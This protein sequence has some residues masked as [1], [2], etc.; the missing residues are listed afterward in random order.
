MQGVRAGTPGEQASSGEAR[1]ATSEDARSGTDHLMKEVVEHVN[2]LAALR[3]VRANK[4]SPGIDGMTVVRIPM[5]WDTRSE[6]SGTPSERSDA[7]A[8][9]QYSTTRCWTSRSSSSG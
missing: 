2:M 7:G 8:V 1:T 6:S 9:V 5:I 3:R 4:E